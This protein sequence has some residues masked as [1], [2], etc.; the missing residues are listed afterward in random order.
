[1]SGNIFKIGV[2]NQANPEMQNNGGPQHRDQPMSGLHFSA[3]HF[4]AAWVRVPCSVFLQCVLTSTF[5]CSRRTHAGCVRTQALSKPTKS[6]LVQ[7]TFSKSGSQTRPI[8]RCRTMAGRNI[9]INPCLVF[10]FLPTIFL[11]PG[12]VFRVFTMCPD[13]NI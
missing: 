10:I 4:S 12:F 7:T 1:M 6:S 2:A 9:A 8:P 11:L 5:E 13:I 3:H